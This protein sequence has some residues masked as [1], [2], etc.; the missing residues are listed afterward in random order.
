MFNEFYQIATDLKAQGEPFAA[1]TVVRN[2]AP[3]SGK[4][5][6]KAIVKSDGILRGWVGG[7]CIYSIMMKEVN[8]ALLDGKPR[9]V[10]VS[11]TPSESGM[12]GIK[13]YK[14]TCFSGGAIDLYIEPVLPKPHII[15]LGKSII[16]RAL[17]KI[18]KAADYRLTLVAE[19]VTAEAF[20]EADNIQNHF[21]LGKIP[22]NAATFIVVAT[23]GD[24]D[25]KALNAALSVKNRYVSFISSKKKRETVFQN[26][27]QQGITSEQLNAINAPAGFDINAKTPEE[28]AI[29]ILA[30][31]IKEFRTKEVPADSFDKPKT[32]EAEPPKDF[33]FDSRPD[34]IINPVCGLPISKTMSKYVYEADGHLFYFC[35]DGCK[36]KF[37]AD[38]QKYIDNPVPLGTGM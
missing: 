29:S 28:V 13:E 24:N 18:A 38:P 14:M 31:I 32:E 25:E 7:G 27:M 23:Q 3:S 4:T 17:I 2:E 21:D 10:R 35:C 34:S 30:E 22:F 20:P 6:D 11:T 16:G 36:N 1:V 9:F 12:V 5:G 33:S 15:V 8:E 37:E 26:L 19:D